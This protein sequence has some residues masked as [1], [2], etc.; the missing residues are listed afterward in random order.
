MDDNARNEEELNFRKTFYTLADRVEKLFSRL[1]KLE[2]VREKA[3]E[4]KGSTH[5]DDG[6]DPPP[7]PSAIGSSSYSSHHHNRNS[8]IASQKP[9]F[10]FD[11]KF[12]LPMYSG[13]SNV[14]NRNNWI[15]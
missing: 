7:S 9:F 15:R 6:G 14:E 3:L 10:K 1:E 11:V 2:S 12:D 5:G 13:E 4:G 8:G